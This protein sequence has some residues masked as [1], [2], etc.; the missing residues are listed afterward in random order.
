MQ[1]TSSR[2]LKLRKILAEMIKEARIKTGKSCN[3]VE[4]EFDIGSGVL[5]R[6][7]NARFDCKFIT[8]WKICEALDVNFSELISELK[9]V[10]GDKFSLIDN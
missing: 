6:I 1:Y 9:N 4:E 8:L 7:E 2:S 5:N 10:L 3:K